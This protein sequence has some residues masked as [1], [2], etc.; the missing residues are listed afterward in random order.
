MIVISIGDIV[1]PWIVKSRFCSIHFTVTR[2]NNDQTEKFVL[3]YR[4]Y[5]HIAD[6]YIGGLQSRFSVIM[7]KV[8]NKN[9]FNSIILSHKYPKTSR[10]ILEIQ[11]NKLN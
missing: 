5:R 10:K 2:P 6:C 8:I 3:L 11:I 7:A 4:E 9:T 1:I